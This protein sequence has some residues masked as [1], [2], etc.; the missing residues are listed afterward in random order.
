MANPPRK[1]V[2]TVRMDEQMHEDLK[3]F[4]YRHRL[5]MED[6]VCDLLTMG[7]DGEEPRKTRR[8]PRHDF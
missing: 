3:E 4:A 2:L 7:I 6:V 5:S 1:R 8:P